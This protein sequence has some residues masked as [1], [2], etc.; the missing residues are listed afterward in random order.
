MV[1]GREMALMVE[2]QAPSGPFLQFARLYV[3]QDVA[4]AFLMEFWPATRLHNI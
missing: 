4:Q 3:C 2:K 1:S